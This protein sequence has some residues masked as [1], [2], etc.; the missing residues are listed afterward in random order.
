MLSTK[1]RADI[2]RLIT[3]SEIKLERVIIQQIETIR[4]D[5][6]TLIDSK[7]REYDD[8]RVDLE[9]TDRL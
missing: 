9:G 7:L 2:I 3:E 1:E 4:Q 6:L 8:K 5:T